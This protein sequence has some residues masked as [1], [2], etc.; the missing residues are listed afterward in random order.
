MKIK[1]CV[2]MSQ[3]LGKIEIKKQKQKRNLKVEITN[4]V[5]R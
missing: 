5:E 2:H 3:L 4:F 1:N